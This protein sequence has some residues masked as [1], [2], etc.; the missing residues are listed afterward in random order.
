ML[1]AY[2]SQEGLKEATWAVRH[3]RS[4]LNYYMT[5]KALS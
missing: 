4:I 5:H 2:P 1:H 3:F